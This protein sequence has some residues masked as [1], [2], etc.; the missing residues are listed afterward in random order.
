MANLAKGPDSRRKDDGYRCAPS[1]LHVR[2]PLLRGHHL[3]G[4]PLS[5]QR[6][7]G[8]RFDGFLE[9]RDVFL[10]GG[11]A[12]MRAAVRRDQDRRDVLAEAA[13]DFADL[14]DAVAAVEM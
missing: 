12:D 11:A 1:I 4:A 6:A 3:L 8:G 13:A 14:G 10:A 9:D 7:Q 5:E 2:R